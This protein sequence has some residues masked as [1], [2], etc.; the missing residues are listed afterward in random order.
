[1]DTGLFLQALVSGFLIGG[2]YSLIAVGLTL[3]FGVMNIINF[4]HGSLLM[5]GMYFSYWLL[6]IYG[7]DPYLSILLTIPILFVIGLFIQKIVINPVIRTPHLNQLLLTLGLLLFIENLA[8]FLWGP[9]YRMVQ[10][11]YSAATYYVG[12]LMI[13][14][15]RLVACLIAFILTGVLFIFLKKTDTGKAIRAASQDREG[16]LVVG[17]NFSRIYVIAFG[18]GAACAGAA[19]SIIVPFFYVS[20][21][22]GWVFVLS[23]FIIVVLGG[24]GSF[25]GALLG[26]IIIGMFETLA[27]LYISSSLKQVV[28]L[29]IFILILLIKPSGL[30]GRRV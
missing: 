3:I 8:L 20:P 25:I 22:V 14:I 12:S 15:P 27:A 16:A 21:H 5:L 29:G 18:I 26:G 6:T 19:G 11:S 1:M 9:D 7:I 10:V 17:I 13:S 2:V 4:A 24:M 28:S 23:A 30:F